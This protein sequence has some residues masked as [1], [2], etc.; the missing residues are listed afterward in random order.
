MPK[1]PLCDGDLSATD[2]VHLNGELD[3]EE[4]DELDDMSDDDLDEGFEDD[5][6]DGEES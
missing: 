2:I 1:C 6:D 4:L 3:D 5:E